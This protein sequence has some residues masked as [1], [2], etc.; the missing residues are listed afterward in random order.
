M[1]SA[2]NKTGPLPPFL[3][4]H[5]AL[6]LHDIQNL[7][8]S[9]T[10]SRR[11][12]RLDRRLGSSRRKKKRRNFGVARRVRALVTRSPA[13][14][15]QYPSEVAHET[16]RP[17]GHAFFSLLHPAAASPPFILTFRFPF[18]FS[19]FFSCTIAPGG[20][21]ARGHAFYSRRIA[22]EEKADTPP[23]TFRHPET[24]D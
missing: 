11:R 3:W 18:G 24:W 20:E 4:T 15:I 13:P 10:T 17:A 12:F 22:R 9:E 8:I 14:P 19:Y 6:P 21:K 16:T 2:P 5:L 7:D 1:Q 23:Q